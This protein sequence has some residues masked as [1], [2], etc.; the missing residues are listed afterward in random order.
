MHVHVQHTCVNM[1]FHDVV[2]IHSSVWVLVMLHLH[3][4]AVSALGVCDIVWHDLCICLYMCVHVCTCFCMCLHV[5]TC[6]C[7]HV[8]IHVHVHV[9]TVCTCVY[10]VYMCVHVFVVH[11]FACVCMFIQCVHVC[12]CLWCILNTSL[13]FYTRGRVPAPLHRAGG[14]PPEQGNT[15]V[16]GSPH[17]P[18]HLTGCEHSG[19][20]DTA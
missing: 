11:V 13:S 6:T 7:V 12:M 18:V 14:H 19:H 5:C 3:L 17:L 8:Y 2:S 10:S 20:R 1:C 9:C 15:H 16:C 4:R